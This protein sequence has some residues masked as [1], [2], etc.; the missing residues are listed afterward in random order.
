MRPLFFTCADTF[1]LASSV[2]LVPENAIIQSSPDRTFGDMKKA[3]VLSTKHRVFGEDQTVSIGCGRGDETS[4]TATNRRRRLQ[5]VQDPSACNNSTN[6]FCW[7]SCLEIPNAQQARGY[8]NEGY[9]LYCLDPSVLAS[10][11]NQVSKAME[12]CDSTVHNSNCMGSWQP[13]AP[14]VAA[15]QV[16]VNDEP[17][18]D[19]PFC[20]G[21]TSMYMDGFHWRNTVCVIYLFPSWILS[22]QAK[23][24]IASIG[25]LC[26]GAALE[27]VIQQRRKVV[28]L[29]GAGYKRLGASALFYGVQL[30]LGYFLMLVVMTYSGPLF[31]CV[32]LGLVGGHVL[33]NA[34]DALVNKMDKQSAS[35][36][37]G[38]SSTSEE[39]SKGCCCEDDNEGVP[40]GSTPCCQNSL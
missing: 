29:L 12:P 37:K 8:L 31:M 17:A 39:I 25:T 28:T 7:M 26:S 11:G 13:T 5:H 40:E 19:Q 24:A 18:S 35:T 1:H 36:D 20:Y 21:G 30:T 22:S 15:S 3:M 23:L 2:H 6:F 16:N 34:K 4:T 10:S 9:S 27:K 32:I 14:G 33:F 38:D